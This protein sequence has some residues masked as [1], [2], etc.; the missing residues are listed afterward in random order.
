M[1][2]RTQNETFNL[3]IFDASNCTAKPFKRSQ[4]ESIVNKSW[5]NN[6]KSSAFKNRL[7]YSSVL[8]KLSP[9]VS[10]VAGDRETIRK[11]DAKTGQLSTSAS[12]F[13]ESHVKEV[14]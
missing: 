13:V 14:D 6:K 1:V 5:S 7:E 4:V 9:N 11:K 3:D 10:R 8:D 12:K 2:K